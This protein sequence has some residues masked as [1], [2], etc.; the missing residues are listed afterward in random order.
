MK[1]LP[2]LA[3]TL[4]ALASG[5]AGAATLS[6]QTD[7]ERR[8]RNREEALAAYHSSPQYDADRSVDR[9]NRTLRE[10]SHHAAQTVRAKTHTSAQKVRGFTHRQ[11]EKV[12]DFTDKENA[13]YGASPKNTAGENAKN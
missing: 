11:A 9:D 8:D 3:L 12:R 13:K 5:I 2:K 6:S 4:V 10:K 7:Q 1:I